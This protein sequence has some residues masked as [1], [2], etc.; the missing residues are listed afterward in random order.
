MG[1]NDFSKYNHTPAY[2]R[3][4]A[5]VYED[6]LRNIPTLYYKDAALPIFLVQSPFNNTLITD[7]LHVILT[8]MK[9][10]G[11]NV[12]YLP[13][14]IHAPPEGCGGHPGTSAHK[15]MADLL[16]PQIQSIMGW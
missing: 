6:F 15:E 14:F 10:E 8:E 13:A 4:F 5:N 3:Q 2:S 12:H 9:A 16:V 1:S 11:L 7:A